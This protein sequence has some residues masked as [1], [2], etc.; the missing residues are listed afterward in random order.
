MTTDPWKYAHLLPS[1][2]HKGFALG[3]MVEVLCATLSGMMFGLH[4]VPMYGSDSDPANKRRLSQTYLVC[5][6]DFCIPLDQFRHSLQ[7][8][9]DE[10]RSQPAAEGECVMMPGDPEIR[11]TNQRKLEGIP[12]DEAVWVE[13]MKL[14]DTYHVS[15]PDTVSN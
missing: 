2:G 11:I 7:Q 15:L 4:T 3:A 12:L 13:L 9:T 14:A 6:P 5:R 10:V 8:M 1:G